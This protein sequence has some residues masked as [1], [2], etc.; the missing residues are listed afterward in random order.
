MHIEALILKVLTM[1]ER[2]IKYQAM[3]F[4]HARR[5]IMSKRQDMI[6]DGAGNRIG[7][8][9]LWAQP[10]HVPRKLV[11]Q[12]QQRQRARRGRLPVHQFAAGRGIIGLT[13]A[14]PDLLVECRFFLE[15]GFAI[16]VF[17]PKTQNF[18][19]HQLTPNS[20]IC[21]LSI[22]L[23]DTRVGNRHSDNNLRMRDRILG[24]PREFDA[25]IALE[26]AMET[27]WSYGFEAASLDRLCQSMGIARSS[28][29]QAFGDKH[30]LLMAA[31][32]NYDARVKRRIEATFDH[33][34]PF[35]EALR[36][37]LGKL[38]EESTGADRRGC[39]LG[40]VTG[41]LSPRDPV[42][43]QRIRQSMAHLETTFSEILRAAQRRGEFDAERNPIAV[44][45]YLVS[46]IQG[47]RIVAKTGPGQ[48]ELQDIVNE[49]VLSLD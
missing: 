27:F 4:R 30:A 5:A 41:E 35:R 28:L 43:T 45:R 24:R 29:Y 13:E 16:V 25:E 17:E 18:V 49:I 3:V 14:I 7:G 20:G 19:D 37:F 22:A 6:G 38:I 39:L 32:D 8:I 11:E 1:F 40:N 44:A 26:R 46:A 34:R 42:A 36:N 23:L 2:Q 31:L 9:G 15:P 48:A 10:E 47:L 21:T 12:H 33:N